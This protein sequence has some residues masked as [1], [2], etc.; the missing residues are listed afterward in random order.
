[1]FQPGY[2]ITAGGGSAYHDWVHIENACRDQG[3][4]DI[5]LEDRTMD[6]GIMSIQGPNSRALL[7]RLAPDMDFSNESFPFATTQTGN[8][9]GHHCRMIRLSFVGEMGW[10]L[11]IPNESC[12]PVFQAMQELGMDLGFKPAGYRA[13]EP[14]AAEKGYRFWDSDL[15]IG[16]TPL[17]AALGFTC[18]LATDVDFIGRSALEA[19]KKIGLRRRIVCFTLDQQVML[20]GLESVFRDGEPVGFLRRGEYAFSMGQPIGY[21]YIDRKDGKKLTLDWIRKGHYQIESFGVK[22]EARAHT[23]SPFDPKHHRIQGNYEDQ[24]DGDIR[25]AM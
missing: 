18:K 17:E 14:L 20:H 15:Q 21:G 16:D 4:T 25:Q 5:K 1:M 6:M 12:V 2:Y 22:Y 9:A 10:E 8:V 11:H 3:L 13:L 7:E 24:F 23:S 19:Q